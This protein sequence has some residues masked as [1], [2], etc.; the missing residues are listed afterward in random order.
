[1]AKTFFFF[2]DSGATRC[3]VTPDCVTVAELACV[4]QDTFL[5]LGNGTRVLSRGMVQGAPITLAG[6][7]TKTDFTVSRLLHDVDIVLGVNWLKT[8][9]PII[10]CSS[11]RI[12]MPNAIRTALIEGTWLSSEN[13]IGTVKVLSDSAGL[14]N[15]QSEYMRNSLAILKTPKFWSTINSRTNF[16][17]QDDKCTTMNCG[18]NSKL[19]IQTIINSDIYT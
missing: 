7:T 8:I 9:N 13:A 4:S 6:V 17:R 15:V 5:E 11:G 3:F 1:M 2:F 14:E 10:D 12:Y 16:S 18:Q 19:F